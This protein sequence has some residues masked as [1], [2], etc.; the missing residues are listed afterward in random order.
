MP[1][2]Y[3]TLVLILFFLAAAVRAQE[4]TWTEPK[5][6]I[7]GTVLNCEGKPAAGA[8]VV[9]HEGYHYSLATSGQ[10]NAEGKFELE[11]TAANHSSLTAYTSDL[12]E[13]ETLI[14]RPHLLRTSGAFDLK[15]D[16]NKFI[17]CKFVD[18]SGAP[19]PGVQVSSSHLSQLPPVQSDAQGL[20]QVPLRVEWLKYNKLAGWTAKHGVFVTDPVALKSQLEGASKDPLLFQE[21]AKKKPLT[22]KVI[23]ENDQPVRGVRVMTNVQLPDQQDSV[24]LEN[25]QNSRQDTNENGEAIFEWFP[26]H[27]MAWA[28][29]DD[30]KWKDNGMVRPKKEGDPFI[31]RVVPRVTISGKV[32]PLPDV[33]VT[34]MLVSAFGIR[35]RDSDTFDA[36]ATRCD[37]DGNFRL[38]IAANRLLITALH[39]RD[40]ASPY[41]ELVTPA[42]SQALSAP[43]ELKLAK[44]VPVRI[45]ISGFDPKSRLPNVNIGR[46]FLMTNPASKIKMAISSTTSIEQTC[47]D[48]GV[49]EFKLFPGKYT[50]RA[51]QGEWL[52][53]KEIEIE[54]TPFELTLKTPQL[55]AREVQGKLL[56]DA[57]LL[58]SLAG[59][60]QVKALP[61]IDPA[62]EGG[63]NE[64]PPSSEV[65][66]A[67]VGADGSF[68]L[69]IAGDWAN[70]FIASDDGKWF[71]T[72]IVQWN[73]DPVELKLEPAASYA[74]T[75]VDA[76]NKPMPG[77]KVFAL[78]QSASQLFKT[79]VT[80][81]SKGKFDFPSL[82]SNCAIYV[83]N[84]TR[85]GN[86]IRAFEPGEIRTN[87][88]LSTKPYSRSP[89]PSLDSA[90]ALAERIASVNFDANALYTPTLIILEGPEAATRKY[91][92][93]FVLGSDSNTIVYEYS[94]F[95]F[96]THRLANQELADWI[97]EQLWNIP[98]PGEISLIIL[99]AQGKLR[100]QAI[101]PVSGDTA[102][103]EELLTFLKKHA[104]PKRN[105]LTGL[106]EALAKA[107]KEGK[108][109]IVKHSGTRCYPC[110]LLS[111]W[112]DD[113]HELLDKDYLHFDFD[114]SR[115]EGG[116]E[117]A[118]KTGADKE[119]IPYFVIMSAE[120]EILATSNSLIGN[121][122]MPGGTEAKR[123][124]RK[125]LTTTAKTLTEKEIDSLIATL[126]DDE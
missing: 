82:P 6:K 79:S 106:D 62:N 3:F 41:L 60:L 103:Q 71:A 10:T 98:K 95:R 74:G 73:E 69:E 32:L 88:I 42:T 46:F 102:A 94:P 40:F 121:I 63:E 113:H 116:F 107:K 87:A 56:A 28:H 12:R 67:E 31:L 92:E 5:V 93:E 112:L 99:N 19:I 35:L 66:N 80:S 33:E 64:E 101:F 81:D 9:I 85:D 123:H 48:K 17:T 115:D 75:L 44:G 76:N 58:E 36:T 8:K 4:K 117:L 22:V 26:E 54:D 14:L 37:R 104:L 97:K 59:K 13:S 100:E 47:N 43:I 111:R 2:R 7:H 34:G 15:L 27:K 20:A 50:L 126:E 16:A 45:A 91:V 1:S 30:P 51:A 122:G 89:L 25:L 49:A 21:V 61:V 114:A 110:I 70:L 96:G 57:S 72:K 118:Q 86:W 23:D 65:V 77:T 90:K 83:S 18:R 78:L 38:P 68:S 125:M 84:D 29:I 124:L 120:G 109:V 52:Q 53:D 108:N 11:A 39:D 24:F 105:A 55:K 119:G